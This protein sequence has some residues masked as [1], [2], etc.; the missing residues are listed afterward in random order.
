MKYLRL[1]TTNPYYNL[2]I[3]EYL[4]RHETDDVFMLWQNEPTVVIGKNQNAYAE[5]NLSYAKE[6]G[7]HVSRRITGGG[8]VYH[9][10]GN[11]NYTFISAK[12]NGEHASYAF[13]AAPILRALEKLGLSCSLSG[14]NDLEYEGRKFS[15]NAQHAAGERILHHGTI[16]F[17]TDVSVMSSVLKVDKEKLAHRAIKSCGSRVVNLREV[18]DNSFEVNDLIEHIEGFVKSEMNAE[19]YSVPECEQI[20]A[21]RER[22]ESDEWIYSE[23]RYLTSYSV[24]RKKKYPFGIVQIELSLDGNVIENAVI[25]GDFFEK[26][27][28][29]EL[30]K[31]LIGRSVNNLPYIDASRYINGMTF[32]DLA[33]LLKP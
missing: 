5:V 1:K 8:A 28:I 4:L 31:A 30:E 19:P 16:L 9:D 29:E 24:Q 6:H 18:L 11:I 7:I 2:A 25:S 23:K 12:R 21:F 22:N 14:R 27:S 20:N 3:E 33:A 13:F 17:D 15:G 26:E 32:S 10:T